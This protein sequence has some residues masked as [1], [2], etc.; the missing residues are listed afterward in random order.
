MR[1]G[2]S[3]ALHM[4]LLKARR[5]PMPWLT[6]V[7]IALPPLAGAL[8]MVIL[9]DPER[10]RSMGLLGAKAALVAGTADWPTHLGFLTQGLA[11]GGFMVFTFVA[12][13]VFGREFTERMAKELLALPVPRATIVTA[14]LAT[15]I[16]WTAA[17]SLVALVTSLLL[18][19]MVGLP[20]WSGAMLR[21]ALGRF[22]L[23]AGLT[24][25]LALPGA[26]AASMGRSYLPAVGVALLMMFLAQVLGALGWGEWFPWAVPALVSGAAGPER[27]AVG[28]HAYAIILAVGAASA[29]ATG[30]WWRSAD[31]H[32]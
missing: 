19:A 4:E 14:K 24:V 22:A 16:G 2:L 25:L 5:S 17:L 29:L 8:F 6:A 3:A 31:H 30:W 26:L 1:S 7:A 11:V 9:K 28:A 23:V 10:A 18:G 32:G 13:W 20:G 12:A 15:V 27:Q 21:E